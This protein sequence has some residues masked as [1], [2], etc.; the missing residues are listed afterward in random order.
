MQPSTGSDRPLP[1]RARASHP[2]SP[3]LILSELEELQNNEIAEILGISLEAVKIRLHRARGKLRQKM[4]EAC[5][6]Y[7]DE[8]GALACDRK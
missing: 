8:Q 3:V 2:R 6:L 1:T 5:V 4:Q 7:H